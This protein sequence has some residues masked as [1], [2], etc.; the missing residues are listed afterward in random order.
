MFKETGYGNISG[1]LTYRFIY[2]ETRKHDNLKVYETNGKEGEGYMKR[3]IFA[4][5]LAGVLILGSSTVYA[6]VGGIDIIGDTVVEIGTETIAA[7]ADENETEDANLVQSYHGEEEIKVSSLQELEPG[8]DR[9]VHTSSYISPYITSIKNQNPYGT[10]WAHAAMASAEADLWKKG[11]A[12]STIDLSEWQLAYFFYHTV[13]D[14][15]GGT[16]GDSVTVVTDSSAEDYLDRGGNQ[17]LATYRLATWQ[18]VTQEAD[19]PYSTVY[20]DRTKTLDDALAYGKDAYHLENAYWVSMKD[21]DIVKQLIMEYGA[22]AA[23]YYHD[24]A[25]FNSSSQ[26]NRSEPLAEYKPTGTSTNHAITIVGWDDNYSKDNFGT[27]KPSSNGAWLCKNSWGSNWSKDGLFYI[28]YE[29]SPNLNGNAYFYDYGTGDNYDYNYQYDGGV[30]MSTYSVANAANV[31][32][33]NSAETLKAVGFYTEDVQYTCT[34]K[35]YKNCTGNPVSGTLVSTQTATEPYAGFHTVVLDTPVDLNAGDTYSVVVYQTTS[36][37]TPKVPIDVSFSW[38]WLTGVS[39]AKTGQSFISSSGSYWQDVS[40]SGYNCRIKAYTD[41]RDTTTPADVKVSRITLSASTGLTLTKGQTQKLTATVAPAN[42]TNKTV[43]WKTSNKNVATVSENGLVTAVGG[44]DATITCTAKD[45]SNVKATCKVTV[46]VPVSGIQ[47]SQ[48]SAAL[49]VG[50]TLTLTKTIY[51]SDA[52]NQ[53]VTWMSSSDAV[54]SVDS[55]GK[56]TAKTAGSAVIT[57]KSVSD[58]SVVGIC[59][60]TVKAKVQTPSEIK[61]NKITLNKTTASVTKGKTLQLIATVTPGNATKKEVKWSTSNKNVATVSENGLVT[62]VGGG[63]ATITCTAKDG[64]NVKATC[65]VTV[66]VPVSGI[67]LSQTSAAL[68]VGDTLTLTKTIYPSDATNQ[69]VTW[70]SSSDAVA[71]VD[72]NGKITAKTA[73]SAVITCKSVSDNSV[74]GICNVTVKA[75][76]QT[77]SEIKV[78]KI[79]L[80]KTTASVTKG[81]TL[82]LIATVTPGNATKKEVKWSTSNKN[83]AMVSTSGLVTAKSAG[84]ATITC[85]AQDGSGVKATCKI[86]VKNPVVKVTK[87]T[88][89]KTTATLAPKETLTLKATVTPTNATNKAVTWKSSNTKIATVSSSGKVTAKAAGTVTITCRAKDGS[90]KK[91]TCKITVYTNTEAYVARIY[92][93]ALGRAAEPAGLKYWVGE[94][95]AKRKTPVEVAE[96]FFFAPEFTN[97]KL[98]NTAYVKVLYRTFMGREADQG[99]LNYWIGRLNKGESRKSVLEAFAGCPEFKQIVKSFGL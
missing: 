41:K 2:A 5:F 82:Q 25:Y 39:S 87:V 51:P 79:T 73:G 44:G 49:T 20:N 31:Y 23:S 12:D 98:N 69:A 56:I 99:G 52:T 11:L 91:A 86:T 70:M 43:T 38:N 45:G 65:K 34:I 32:T 35:I 40:A 36:S 13:E 47:L 33:A 42:A 59:N 75:K 66:T 58:N 10:C 89:N 3:R 22:C 46:T 72:S 21:R 95:N 85:T 62:A 93:K 48:T 84:T 6:E 16:A 81:K 53:A 37:G 61:V 96:L 4:G 14:P 67:Q 27:Y 19:A 80:N 76:V 64:S 30:G 7:S 71:S 54:A 9:G 77:P 8:A 1:F 55:N 26:W 88:L 60:V 50:D 24:S 83:V 74:V 17:Q 92:T 57:C 90:G 63:D 78:N 18:G 94:I 15:L 68:T 97:K 29:D 28:S